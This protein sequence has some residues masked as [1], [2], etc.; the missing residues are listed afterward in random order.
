MKRNLKVIAAACLLLF[1]GDSLA[2]ATDEDRE[3]LRLAALEALISAPP[4][5]ALPIVDK[6]LAGDHSE[7]LKER[8]LFILSQL[9]SPEAQSRLMSFAR[10]GQGEVRLEAI[11]MV[12]ISGDK[13]AM[14]GLAEIYSNG[15]SD[16]REAVLE[17][18][19]IADDEDAV[20]AIAA[21]TEDEDEF[22]SAVEMLGAMGATDKLRNLRERAGLSQSLIE[23]YAISGDAETL[24]QLALD[25]SN[26]ETQQH[27]IEGLGIIGDDD[28]GELLVDIYRNSKSADVREAAIEGLMIAG[29]DAGMLELYRIAATSDE[30]QQIMEMLVAMDSKE[31]WDLIDAAFEGLL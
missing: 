12:G 27:A 3:S 8:A 28:V 19:L 17:A 18:Y 22:S 9:D 31:V 4:E 30:K 14:A 5:R 25:D 21:A 24:R 26:P 10:D 20:F 13:Q 23:A 7:E 15:D 11:R 2:Q 6:V 16:T 29:D 1:V